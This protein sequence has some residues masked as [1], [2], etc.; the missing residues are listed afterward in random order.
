MTGERKE[1]MFFMANDFVYHL[2]QNRKIDF[3]KY[4]EVLELISI[5]SDYDGE[6]DE[7][8]ELFQL[9]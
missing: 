5:C 3:K 4:M 1:K 9:L 6:L 2:Y 8:S 7:V